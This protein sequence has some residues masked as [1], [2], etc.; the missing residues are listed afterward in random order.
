MIDY[1]CRKCAI[2]H[3]GTWP[4]G[5]L[6]TFHTGECG[7]C[8]EVKSVCSYDDWDHLFID[9]QQVDLGGRD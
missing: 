3:G 6:A 1:I 7:V 8:H 2:E 5:H 9:K 4:E